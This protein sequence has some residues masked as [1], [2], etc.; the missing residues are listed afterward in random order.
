M[1][2]TPPF[3]KGQNE[4]P[5]SSTSTNPKPSVTLTAPKLEE[6][7]YQRWCRSFVKPWIC[8]DVTPIVTSDPPQLGS[9][10]GLVLKTEQSS[11]WRDK[12]ASKHSGNFRWSMKIFFPFLNKCAFIFINK[13]WEKSD[14]NSWGSY[15]LIGKV[16]DNGDMFFERACF[17]PY[18][19]VISYASMHASIWFY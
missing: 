14:Q 10:K 11:T 5:R 4:G 1:K 19:T 2:I 7:S 6:H 18:S 3:S 17:C 9:W 15:I 16:H 13:D 12:L 8:R